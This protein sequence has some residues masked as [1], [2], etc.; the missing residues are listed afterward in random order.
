MS[1]EDKYVHV[2]HRVPADVR[3]MAQENSEY[4]EITELVRSIYQKK[5]YGSSELDRDQIDERLRELRHE[6]DETRLELRRITEEYESDL[7]K[8]EVEIARLE[9][10]KDKTKS[11]SD[12]F[13]GAIDQL[14]ARVENGERVFPDLP[15]VR[16][17]ANTVGEP[18]EYVVEK[19]REKVPEAPDQLFEEG[20]TH[21]GEGVW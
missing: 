6:R 16:A 18:P 7:Q 9:E 20:D 1:N 3:D 19:V 5:A 10:R 17:A 14:I 15:G 8:L 13:E 2:S 21:G 4:G 11:K 12:K